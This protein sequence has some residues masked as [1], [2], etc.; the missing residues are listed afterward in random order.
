M[1]L[2]SFL[3]LSRVTSEITDFE[4]ALHLK[5][6][7][8]FD[9]TDILTSHNYERGLVCSPDLTWDAELAII[10]QTYSEKCVMAHN[11]VALSKGLGENLYGGSFNGI[12]PVY[13]VYSWASERSKWNCGTST[14]CSAGTGHYTQLVWNTTRQ[15]GC[16]A[17]NCV[18]GGGTVR[19]L[20]VVCNY[21]P[22]GNN[23]IQGFICDGN[24]GGSGSTTSVAST[25][26]VSTVIPTVIPTK[27]PTV[28]PTQFP[29]IIPTVTPTK[30]PSV[31]PTKIPSVTP[32]KIPSVTPTIIPTQFPTITPTKIPTVTTS[33]ILTQFPTVTPTQFPTVTP[34]K[35]P[36]V[37]PIVIPT[38]T[39][40]ISTQFPTIIPSPTNPPNKSMVPTLLGVGFCVVT[41][42]LLIVKMIHWNYKKELNN[43]D[44]ELN[45]KSK[46]IKNIE[47]NS[48]REFMKIVNEMKNI[49]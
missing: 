40:S 17:T 16:G 6:I 27:I 42:F 13:A 47:L 38:V 4:V 22:A 43:N 5:R 36:T 15:I 49:K 8:D 33:I 14:C 37:T 18:F 10:A 48:E 46:E 41:Y 20:W 12:T 26:A 32:T 19:M 1:I 24:C 29:T 23:A 21:Y 7:S 35:I 2:L 30:I 39:P 34:T 9:K 31:T 11:T 45:Q 44:V 25:N 3:I 28:T